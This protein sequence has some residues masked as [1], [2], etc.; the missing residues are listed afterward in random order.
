[1]PSMTNFSNVSTFAGFLAEANNQT[2]GWFWSGMNL[3]IFLVLFITLTFSFGWEAALFSAGYV[4]IIV[5][6]LLVFLGLQSMF[7]TSI[8]IGIMLIT[9]IIMMWSKN[10]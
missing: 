8:I 10:N 4:C 1:M 6:V 9:F 3:M 7:V 5:S 2:S